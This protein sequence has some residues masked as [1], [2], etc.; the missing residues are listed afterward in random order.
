MTD[1]KKCRSALDS[2][3]CERMPRDTGGRRGWNE[4]RGAD[5]L[6]H[7]SA[8]T[9]EDQ[10]ALRLKPAFRRVVNGPP[11]QEDDGYLDEAPPYDPDFDHPRDDKANYEP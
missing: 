3:A 2:L 1:V 6:P 10:P 7:E 9:R 4:Y 5:A 8:G 11:P